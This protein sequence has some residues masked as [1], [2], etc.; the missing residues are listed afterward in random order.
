MITEVVVLG[1]LDWLES[2][3]GCCSRTRNQRLAAICSFMRYVQR[4]YPENLREIQRV[5]SIP[6][7]KCKRKVINFLSP[8]V[9]CA[10][11]SA[12]DLSKKSGRRDSAKNTHFMLKLNLN[13]PG[14][15]P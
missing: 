12:P 11:L 6:Q 7:K 14:W 3:R 2:G 5:L 13:Y 4:E 10:I 8:D 9:I 15:I 1:F